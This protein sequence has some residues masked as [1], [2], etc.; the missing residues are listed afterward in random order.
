MGVSSLRPKEYEVGRLASIRST[1]QPRDDVLSGKLTDIHFAAQLDKIVRDP[2][3]Y[4]VY[5]K[6]D[7]F[8]E[9]SYPTAGLK[10]LLTRVFGRLT[11]AHGEAGGYGVTRAE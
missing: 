8:F 7:E 6:P 9:I 3:H 1:C 5:G 4:P 10:T 2:A 11:G